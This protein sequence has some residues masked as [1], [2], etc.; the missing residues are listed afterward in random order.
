MLLLSPLGGYGGHHIKF[1]AALVIY[2]IASVYFINKATGIKAK[3]LSCALMLIPPF[4]LYFP[5][6][7]Y[8]D[9]PQLA[10]PSDVAH[11]IGPCVAFL[12]DRSGKLLKLTLISLTLIFSAW[13]TLYGYDLWL[14]KLNFGNYTTSVEETLSR[15]RLVNAQ[16]N[17]LTND[18]FKNRLVVLDFWTTSCG[19][20]F[21][22][23]P[24]LQEKARKYKDDAKVR[25]YA[26]NIP[27]ARDT[28]GQG[29]K[30]IDKLNYSFNKL[31]AHDIDAMKVFGIYYFPTVLVIEN[32]NKI[33][34]RGDI[35]GVE[36]I[37]SD[38]LQR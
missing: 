9:G 5:L 4:A 15:F 32:G 19:I 11:F 13:T 31:Y 26:V 14:N 27:I 21:T 36:E 29:K 35:E 22:K 12:V 37:I 23:F 6:H 3:L 18:D 7:L 8:N 34:Y 38:Y 1:S 17:I 16:D 20:C 25:V 30:T 33:I 2:F 28:L 24:L 10:M